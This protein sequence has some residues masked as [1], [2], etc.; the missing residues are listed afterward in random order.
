MSNKII[1]M[2]EL[3]AAIQA[4]LE[5]YGEAIAEGFRK[6]VKKVTADTVK[7][8]KQTSPRDSGEYASGWVSEEQSPSSSVIYNKKKGSLSHILENGHAIATGGRVEAVPH[9]SRAEREA[10]AELE[11]LTE[12]LIKG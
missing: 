9:I 8:L 6:N 2:G 7:Q 4:E 3:S 11:S 12:E 10:I 5:D 1:S